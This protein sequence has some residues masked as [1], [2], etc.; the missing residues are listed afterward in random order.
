[1]L[2][3]IRDIVTYPYVI[4]EIM[5]G[6]DFDLLEFHAEAVDDVMFSASLNRFQGSSLLDFS[7]KTLLRAPCVR[8]L[9]PVD[10]PVAKRDRAYLFLQNDAADHHELSEQELDYYFLSTGC[11]DIT[12]FALEQLIISLPEKVLCR[13]DCR[14]LCPHCGINRNHSTCD[15]DKQVIDARWE[16]LSKIKL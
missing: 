10:I 7:L 3:D 13:E 14:G 5:P 1:V 12:A 16:A 11:L 6:K 9:E 8:C 4:D 15:C 2:L